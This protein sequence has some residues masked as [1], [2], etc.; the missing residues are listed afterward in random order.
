[1]NRKKFIQQ[2]GLA[3]L[4]IPLSQS[5]L[6]SCA[7]TTKLPQAVNVP[8]FLF[9]LQ[10]QPL[11]YAYDALEPHIDAKTM[12][13]HYSKHAAAYAK[14]ATD[15]FAAEAKTKESLY[16]IME[17]IK[18]YSVKMRNNLGGHFNHE[19]F[20]Q[21][22]AAAYTSPSN[23]L[24]SKLNTAFT[25]FDNF[26]TLFE[27]EALR[28]FGSGWVW[29]Y[30][31]DNQLK[32]GSTANQ[33]NP[34]MAGIDNIQGKPILGLDVWEHAYYLKYQNKRADYA[35]AFWNI[36]NWQVVEQRLG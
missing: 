28:R 26:K 21:S 17:N 35:K 20:W 34:I 8:N 29:L 15:A 10:Q 5:L 31:Q 9:S 14:N 7:A 24:I 27:Q 4:S 36:V 13:I 19:F 3:A 18:N 22:L 12:E 25:S 2:T 30:Q 6:S 23:N 32:I 16:S 1:M 11:P 33:D